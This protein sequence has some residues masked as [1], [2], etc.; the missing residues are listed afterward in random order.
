MSE[1]PIIAEHNGFRLEKTPNKINPFVILTPDGFGYAAC[2]KIR[3][4]DEGGFV[5]KIVTDLDLGAHLAPEEAEEIG[6]EIV[7]L[8]QAASVFEKVMND[9]QDVFVPKR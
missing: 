7:E 1:Y 6:M 2:P 3:R 5:A 4:N 8:S 9:L